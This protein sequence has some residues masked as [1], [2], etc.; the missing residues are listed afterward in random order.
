MKVISSKIIICMIGF[1]AI[2]L[3]RILFK[4][5]YLE[6]LIEFDGD[7]NLDAAQTQ[8]NSISECMAIGRDSNAKWYLLNSDEFSNSRLK[9]ILL[10]DKNYGFHNVGSGGC[11]SN[12]NLVDDK[13]KAATDCHAY[14]QQGNGCWHLLKGASTSESEISNSSDP[15]LM[16]KYAQNF[17][18]LN[19]SHYL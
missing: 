14:G 12:L 1:V 7:H 16:I 19:S 18:F 11:T 6:G 5:S 4:P 2:V 10:Q 8:C 13:C 15:K 17:K 3:L 9:P